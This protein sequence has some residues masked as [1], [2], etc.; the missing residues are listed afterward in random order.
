MEPVESV[1]LVTNC[2]KGRSV[3]MT[4]DSLIDLSR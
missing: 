2:G 1:E 3:S 4:A